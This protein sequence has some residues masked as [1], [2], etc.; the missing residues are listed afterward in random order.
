MYFNIVLNTLDIIHWLGPYLFIP[1]I[2]VRCN[3][4]RCSWGSYLSV[5]GYKGI[6]FTHSI[7]K[8][9]PEA[10]CFSKVCFDV[11]YIILQLRL[12][13]FMSSVL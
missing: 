5:G 3:F 7:R 8:A 2:A 10:F 12:I 13:A 6:F 1:V 4:L 11:F 9:S